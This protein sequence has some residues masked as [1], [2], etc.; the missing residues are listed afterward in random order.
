MRGQPSSLA[1]DPQ[2]I[3][4]RGV[5]WLGDA[6]MTTPAM[7]RLRERVPQARITLLTSE[8][9]AELWA[10]HSSIDAVMTFSRA[11]NPWSV[12]RRL[13]TQSF[14]AAV[15]LPNSPR[16]AFEVWLAGIPCR[17]G[18]ARRWRN[19]FLSEPL[20][21]PRDRLLPRRRSV[22]E[23]KRL[24]RE[25]KGRDGKVA[26]LAYAHQIQ[27]YLCLTAALG[28]NPTPLPPKLEVS[29][30]EVEAAVNGFLSQFRG[31][32]DSAADKQPP[33]CLGLNPSA[34]YGPAKRWPVE[35]FTEV[36]R[37]ISK[38]VGNCVWLVFGAAADWDICEASAKMG[39]GRIIN[40][41]GKTSLRQLMA[42]LKN[43]RVLLTNDSGPMHVAAALGTPVV[44]PF[45]STSPELT[46]PGQPDDPQHH[47][48]RANAACSPCFR[49]TCPIDFRCMTG[50]P[51]DRAVKA[52]LE[53]LNPVDYQFRA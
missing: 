49:R 1:S 37:E 6:V 43:C 28:S 52:I 51:V 48:L 34:A 14:E 53:S 9:L 36:T 25:G 26:G 23:V 33:I 4:V 32:K 2:K 15:V 31:A 3:L 20:A 45:G 35:R 5:N 22:S 30:V 47:L 44:V 11:D 40:L 18:Y 13:R 7:Q 50:I 39:G 16:S 10:R 19:W 46:G 21:G 41:A 17:I 24:I 8:K 27:D 42:L 12:A 38:R 29:A